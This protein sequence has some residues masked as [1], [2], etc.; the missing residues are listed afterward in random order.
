METGQLTCVLPPP[1]S[2]AASVSQSFSICLSQQG[3]G[4]IS[5]SKPGA[6]FAGAQADHPFGV[7]P[8]SAKTQVRDHWGMRKDVG[9]W[10]EQD[11]SRKL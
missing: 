6:G 2:A 1:T 4:G 3:H 10:W 7:A 5:S 9:S 8:L 11:S